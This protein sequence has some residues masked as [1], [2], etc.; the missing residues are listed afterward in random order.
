VAQE[1][2][3]HRRVVAVFQPHRY[4]RTQAFFSEFAASF[5]DAD[6]VVLTEVYSAGEAPIEGVGGQSLSLAISAQHENVYYRATLEEITEFLEKSLRS[7]D[8]VLFLG[9]GNLN[10]IVPDVI[11]ACR[12]QVSSS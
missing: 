11:N 2:A 3:T 1:V 6:M 8:L 7:G 9:A 4:S 10:Q 5:A 12:M